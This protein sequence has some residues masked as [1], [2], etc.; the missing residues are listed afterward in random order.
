[1]RRT[2]TVA[3]LVALLAALAAGGCS[4]G[5][6]TPDSS[7]GMGGASVRVAAASD[8]KF[9]LEE[10]AA[11]LAEADPP[12]N[13]LVTYGSSGTFFQ[14]ISN[15]APFDVFLSADLSYPTEL[16][17][18]GLAATEDVFPYAVGR[19]VVWAPNESP[20]DVS[21]GLAVLADPEVRRVAIAN[22]QHA[23]YGRAAVAAMTSA[24]VYEAAQDKLVLGEN[25]A[26]AAEFAVSGNAEVGVFALSLALAPALS[27]RGTYVEVPL[28]SFPRLDQGGVILDTAADRDAATQLRDF[29]TGQDGIE[30]LRSYGFY[31]PGA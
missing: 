28:D 27:S 23:P 29:L 11:A 18:A 6:S 12:V 13:L 7:D 21:A 20:V 19:L 5:T 9:A 16:A 17:E 30:I 14:Q 31:L 3:G 24:G 10:V 4:A 15:G 8:L 2:R 25:V 22:P 26:Q 1:M